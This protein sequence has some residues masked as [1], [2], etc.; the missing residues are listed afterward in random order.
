MVCIGDGC[1][2]YTI[3]NQDHELFTRFRYRTLATIGGR[4]L[5]EIYEKHLLAIMF[6]VGWPPW[7]SDH[8]SC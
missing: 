5:I 4:P 3:D 6:T 2:S 8:T 1:N 7:G